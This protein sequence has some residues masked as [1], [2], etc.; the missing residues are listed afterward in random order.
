MR[1]LRKLSFKHKQMLMIWFSF[2]LV[3]LVA[4]AGLTCYEVLAARAALRDRLQTLADLVRYGAAPALANNDP[5]VAEHVFSTVRASGD[6]VAGCLYTGDGKVVGRFAHS[7]AQF[8]LPPP[9]PD[10][11]SFEDGHFFLY[12]RILLK[13]RVVGT[14]C[15]QS[16]QIIS[17][18]LRQYTR[19]G[20]VLM[21]LCSVVTLALSA[22][23]QRLLAGPILG[24]AR[25][26]RSVAKDKDYALRVPN[27]SNDELGELVDDFN[28]MLGQIQPQDA[29]LHEAHSMLEQRVTN[30]TRELLGEIVERQHA[31]EKL[32]RQVERLT[33]INQLTR[34]V[35]ERVDMAS[36]FHVLLGHLE[37]RLEIDLGTAYN[38]NEE[39]EEFVVAA[40]GPHSGALA[41][42]TGEQIGETI[43]LS[44]SF[45]A[46]ARRGEVFRLVPDASQAN[47]EFIQRLTNVGIK[48]ALAVPLQTESKLLG[49]L[50]V[51]RLKD[52][53]FTSP[54]IDFLRM[55]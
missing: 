37:D 23:I 3:W 4:F 49:T 27:H 35:A 54:E 41:A 39:R 22:W 11:L 53:P 36:V 13:K 50:I 21:G 55:V 14:V 48:R 25:A 52:V 20:A 33:I 9:R 17:E 5:A 40:H 43:L 19:I 30:R 34:A 12:Q 29:A 31:E 45:L 28:E 1:L 24:L 47:A 15:L 46:A 7:G 42:Q 44:P 51:A 18:R 16:G 6:V 38:F 2:C 10:G 8:A 26:A 32:R